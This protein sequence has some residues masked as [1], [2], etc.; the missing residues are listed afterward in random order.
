MQKKKK[1]HRQEQTQGKNK[2]AAFFSMGDE[3]PIHTLS[4]LA[5]AYVT[6]ER[7]TVQAQTHCLPLFKL[8]VGYGT[9][10]YR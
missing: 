9:S 5:F 4:Y 6:T 1:K 10:S 7:K 2:T 8:F 3:I